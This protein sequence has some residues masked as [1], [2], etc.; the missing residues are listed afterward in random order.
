MREFLEF[1]EDGGYENYR[2]WHSEGWDWVSK[3]E[4]NSPLYWREKDG[5]WYQFTLSGF[6]N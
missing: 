6:G 2:L 4:I 3:T 5:E 1:I